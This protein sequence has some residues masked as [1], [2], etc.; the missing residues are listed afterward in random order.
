ME[1]NDEQRGIEMRDGKE[2]EKGKEER[3]GTKVHEHHILLLT[4]ITPMGTS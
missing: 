4:V 3:E 2:E 1:K